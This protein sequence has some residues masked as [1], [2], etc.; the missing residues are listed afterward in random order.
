[1]SS[2]TTSI[3]DVTK[4]SSN[5]VTAVVRIPGPPINPNPQMGVSITLD[6]VYNVAELMQKLVDNG[7]Y[8]QADKDK[9]LSY[10]DGWRMTWSLDTP[11]V[12]PTKAGAIDAVCISS[13]ELKQLIC[14]GVTYIGVGSLKA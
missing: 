14:V 7:T 2:T 12:V 8:K 4:T 5:T 11:S 3:A 13:Q 6:G 10:T 9:W 1:M